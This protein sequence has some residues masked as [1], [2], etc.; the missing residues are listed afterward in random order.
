MSF[1]CVFLSYC[2]CVLDTYTLTQTTEQLPFHMAWHYGLYLLVVKAD[3]AL[4]VSFGWKGVLLFFFRLWYM[5]NV[6]NFNSLHRSNAAKH[7]GP[8]IDVQRQSGW[9]MAKS[10]DVEDEM[11]CWRA[12]T[13]EAEKFQRPIE[14]N[15]RPA[16]ALRAFFNRLL[17][18]DTRIN[19][20]SSRPLPHNDSSLWGI[21]LNSLNK[22]NSRVPVFFVSQRGSLLVWFKS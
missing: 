12:L 22:G 8:S 19:Q 3:T 4:K 18:I 13:K 2:C 11:F 10:L 20:Q 17:C 6:N 9:E 14:D 21:G 16:H 15:C 7:N 5:F 1:Y